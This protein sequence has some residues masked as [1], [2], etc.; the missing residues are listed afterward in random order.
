MLPRR[1]VKHQQFN[2]P[3]TLTLRQ[4]TSALA[5]MVQKGVPFD[6]PVFSVIWTGSQATVFAWSA[7]EAER[8]AARC[9]V[10]LKL[11]RVVPESLVRGRGPDGPRLINGVE[12]YEGQVWKDGNL[13]HSRWWS[14]PPA[15]QE[16]ALFLG[17]ASIFQTDET[18]PAIASAE[19]LDFPWDQTTDIVGK[20]RDALKDPVIAATAVLLV[21]APL[22]FLGG[23]WLGLTAT[24]SR[25][26]E[27]TATLNRDNAPLWASRREALEN[28]EVI[29]DLAD[30]QLLPDQLLILSE[31]AR[32]LKVSDAKVDSWAQEGANLELQ[33]HAP[34]PLDPT[35][36]ITQFEGHALFEAV[37]A[38]RSS[39]SNAVRIQMRIRKKGAPTK[40]AP[41]K[42]A[43]VR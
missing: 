43:V 13:I 24:A 11:F 9:A 7:A 1:Y 4:K 19:I 23:Q 5:I 3:S 12:G 28:R 31:V 25:I 21:S 22:V 10:D 38:T 15:P 17:G 16:W 40:E 34:R 26:E 29:A 32:M 8:Q 27:K 18:V 20:V 36:L 14:T 42:E 2:L 33:I 6:D 37:T 30:L 41:A 35:Y 39:G